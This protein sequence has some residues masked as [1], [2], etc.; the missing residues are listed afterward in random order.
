ME[1]SKLKNLKAVLENNKDNNLL[2]LGCKG[3]NIP[4]SVV[5]PAITP[6]SN[7]GI[8]I[9]DNGEYQKPSWLKQMENIKSETIYLVIDELDKLS[10][11]EQ[12]KFFQILKYHGINGYNFTKE[13]SII[14]TTKNNNS[15]VISKKLLPLLLVY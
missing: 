8:I 14:V 4:N 7:L 12:D 1:N 5:L 6:S 13:V 10:Q 2:L 9:D 15:S 11:D 3:I